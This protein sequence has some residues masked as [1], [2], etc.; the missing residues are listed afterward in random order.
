MPLVRVSMI[1]GKP[2]EYI[3]ALSI[4]IYDALVEAYGMPEGDNFQVLEQLEADTFK[5][6]R[7]YRSSKPRTDDFVIVTIQGPERS[8]A[9]KASGHRNGNLVVR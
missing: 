6:N 5:F 1:K 3:E 2:T 7:Q 8:R 4:S 9:D